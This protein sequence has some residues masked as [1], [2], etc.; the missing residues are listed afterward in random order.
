MVE[1]TCELTLTQ[2]TYE[3]LDGPELVITVRASGTEKTPIMVTNHTYWCVSRHFHF[4][5][6]IYP[7]TLYTFSTRQFPSLPY[8]LPAFVGTLTGPSPL[9]LRRPFTTTSSRSARRVV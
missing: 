7:I 2:A 9:S 1:G 4:L 6:V 5:C 3:L 8:L